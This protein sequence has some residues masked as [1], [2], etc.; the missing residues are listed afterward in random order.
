MLDLLTADY[1][2]VNERLARHY[3]IPD[4]YGSQ[5]PPRDGR[6]TT[7]GGG[8]SAQGSILAVTSHADRTSPVV[9]GKWM[10]E[11]LLGTPPPPPPPNVPALE[12]NAKRRKPP[13]RCANRWSE[14]RANPVCASCHKLM[15]P[16]GFALENFDAVGAWRTRE[17]GGP[18]DASG[19]LADGTQVDGVVALRKALLQRPEVFVHD[20][21]REAADLCARPRPRLPRHAG[22][23]R[24]RARRARAT[25]TVSRRSSSASSTARR[26]RCAMKA[27]RDASA[28][29]GSHA[30]FITKM[31][32]PRRTFLR[33]MGATLALPLLD[34][35]VP[36]LTA[37]GAD[38]R[39]SAPR[40]GAVFVPN[41]AIM[42]Q[43]TPAD[44][45]RRLRASR[46]S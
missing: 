20:D 3:G 14:H 16:I 38:G 17:P 35:M 27:R 32:L 22:G 29:E 39:E 15:D 45:R 2:F 41:G 34:A 13:R 19:Q 42:E 36:A 21:D 43:W 7:R 25:T 28:T 37:L 12:E 4:V 31:S 5:F 9:R 30:M 11:N 1:T 8:C 46:R 24:H 10:L 26:F 33:G 40:F 18:I 44:G 6:P 23:P